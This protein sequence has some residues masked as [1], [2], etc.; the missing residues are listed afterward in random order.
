MS[1]GSGMTGMSDSLDEEEVPPP[2]RPLLA[3]AIC[4]A[5][6]IAITW[7]NPALARLEGHGQI[8]ILGRLI[9]TG[10]I[11]LL[12]WGITFGITLYRAGLGWKIGSAIG[13]PLFAVLVALVKIGGIAALR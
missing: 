5:V 4:M 12:G 8:D 1:V 7:N 13:L 9:G 2:G 3:I 11:G 6:L 10:L